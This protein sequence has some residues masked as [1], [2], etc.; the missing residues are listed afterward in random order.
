MSRNHPSYSKS[1]FP[2][3]ANYHAR[4]NLT[5]VVLRTTISR[6]AG[7]AVLPGES[8]KPVLI[9]HHGSHTAPVYKMPFFFTV[10]L[11]VGMQFATSPM[12]KIHCFWEYA[13]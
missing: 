4:I 6:A 1:M 8:Y 7:R 3:L 2:L 5:L 12:F 10:H 9:L 13:R 11:H